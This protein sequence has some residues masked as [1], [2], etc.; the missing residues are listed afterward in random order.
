MTFGDVINYKGKDLVYLGATL[1]VFYFAVMPNLEISAR[2]KSMSDNAHKGTVRAQK[3]ES[4]NIWCFIEVKKT[5]L[6][7]DRI[8][9]YGTEHTE[10]SLEDMS[11]VIERLDVD[12]LKGLKTEILS[13]GAVSTVVKELAEQANLD[14]GL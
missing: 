8:V 3:A 14:E 7:K 11:E 1:D 4:K 13:D 2:F 10:P 5:V 6:F 9:H 12:D